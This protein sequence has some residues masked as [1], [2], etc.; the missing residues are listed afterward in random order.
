MIQIISFFCW[1]ISL[2]PTIPL[3][4]PLHKFHNPIQTI[5][6]ILNSWKMLQLPS[7]LKHL[8]G[9]HQ[10]LWH[11]HNLN[12]HQTMKNN[13]W[14]LPYLWQKFQHTYPCIH[15]ISTKSNPNINLSPINIS[16]PSSTLPANIIH[17]LILKPLQNISHLIQI[18]PNQC[19]PSIQVLY[20]CLYNA[21]LHSLL[22]TLN[23]FKYR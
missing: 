21:I 7:I 8:K 4:H 23:P 12:M 5:I 15:I 22:T 18:K 9:G 3:G 6:F 10:I 17:Y 2:P 19:P 1:K 13:G 14:K 11:T 16:P 20:N